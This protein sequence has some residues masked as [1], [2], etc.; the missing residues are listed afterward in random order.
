MNHERGKEHYI[1]GWRMR[2]SELAAFAGRAKP[3]IVEPLIDADQRLSQFANISC[4]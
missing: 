3:R 2:L 4:N 1:F